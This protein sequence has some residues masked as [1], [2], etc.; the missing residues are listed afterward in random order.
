MI[1][2]ADKTFD[3]KAETIMLGDLMNSENKLGNQLT[4]SSWCANQVIISAVVFEWFNFLLQSDRLIQVK[5]IETVRR[6]LVKGDC[7]R[8]IE[9][10]T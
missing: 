4:G 5:T 2:N 10:T 1:R 3:P 8:L 7:D 9:M 6:D